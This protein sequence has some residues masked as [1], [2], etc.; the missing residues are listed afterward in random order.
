M[1]IETGALAC[2]HLQD[3][4]PT[5]S[6][7]MSED[8]IQVNF[9]KP[10]PLFPLDTAALL[11][12]QLLPLRIFEPRYR[13]MVEHAL[14]GAGQIAIAVFEGSR[15]KQEYHGRPPLRPAVC[16]GQIMQHEH[17]AD[18]DYAI[19]LQGVCRARIVREFAPSADRLYRLAHLEPVGIDSGAEQKLLGVRE[20]LSEL[21]TDEP[22]SNLTRAKFV[23]QH[24]HNHAIPT[25]IILE[26]AS[27]HLP[28]SRE[29]RYQLLA[30]S[31]AGV[32][33]ALIESE[34]VDLRNLL[35]RA[36]HQH[37][38]YWPKGCSWN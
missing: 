5:Y 11:P 26:L 12:Q 18:G 31:D 14:D 30:E 22:L 28:T 2:R 15:W 20:R 1:A 4:P 27:F 33:A 6:F 29:S 38:E 16:I 3:L 21:L 8:S 35:E 7:L 24:I 36:A 13:Q 9:G 25:E 10:V 32:R 17:Q 37:P 34:L 23:V 19:L